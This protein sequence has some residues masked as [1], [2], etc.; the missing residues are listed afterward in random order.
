MSYINITHIIG[1]FQISHLG[2]VQDCLAEKGWYWYWYWYRYWYYYNYN[3][4]Y[5]HYLI[6]VLIVL[7]VKILKKNSMIVVV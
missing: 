3:Y 6:L 1:V 7:T 2:V 4:N 5:G